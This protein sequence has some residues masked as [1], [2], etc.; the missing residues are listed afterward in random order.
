MFG[1]ATRALGSLMSGAISTD[2]GTFWLPRRGSDFASQVDFN[3]GLVYWISVFFFALVTFLMVFFAVRYRQRPGHEPEKSTSHNTPLEVLWSV[4]P[5]LIVI[6]LFWS[7][8]KTYLNMTVAPQNAYEVLVTGQ[9]WNWLFTYPNGYIDS[10]LHVPVDTP[11]KLT[12]TSEDV[13]HSFFVPD[14]RIKRD[15]IPG[16]YTRLWFTAI[17]TGDYDI[18]CTE[19][20]GTNHWNMLSKLVVHERAEFDSWLEEASDFLSKMPPAEA[21]ELLYNMRGC[22]QCHSVDGT[23]GIA[24]SFLGKFGSEEKLLTGE[25][26]VVEENYIRE[27]IVDPQA[28][29]VAGFDPVMPTYQG[30]LK[31]EEITAII[32]YMKTLSEQ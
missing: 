27:S 19:Y 12:M 15:V 31:D 3:F 28:R 21:G 23:P 24:P 17:E 6:V 2:D 20:C 32:E 29:I 5:T 13:I 8:Y 14:F 22:K 10:Q 11:V 9:K 1:E 30:R 18:L 16:R 7:G 26:V 4:I 25:T